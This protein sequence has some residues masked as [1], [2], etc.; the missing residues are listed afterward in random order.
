[1]I[2][3]TVK[4]IRTEK[5][6]HPWDVKVDRSS[7]FGNGFVM[8]NESERDQVCDL[9]KQWFYDELYDS[10]MQ[11][12]LSFLNNIIIKYGKLNLFCWCAPKRCHAEVIKDYLVENFKG[13]K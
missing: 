13:E 11:A 12:E 2:D 9:Y 8:K 3:I 6:T 7:Y 5:P 4:N 10:A 1:M